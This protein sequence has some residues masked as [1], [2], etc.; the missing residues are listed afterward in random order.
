MA[1]LWPA[2]WPA[3]RTDDGAVVVEAFADRGGK[4]TRT[5]TKSDLE[6]KYGKPE[7]SQFGTLEPDSNRPV[8]TTK[9]DKDSDIDSDSQK[10]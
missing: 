9:G 4:L 7:D 8:G 6:T 2:S 5:F 10:P 3:S 1:R